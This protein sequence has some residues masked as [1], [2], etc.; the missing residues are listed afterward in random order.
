MQLTDDESLVEAWKDG[1]SHA[2]ATLF[3]RYYVP[4]CAHA[5]N[6]LRDNHASKDIVQQVFTGILLSKLQN[7]IIG[8][9]LKGYLFTAV[10][11]RCIRE[12]DNRKRHLV[13]HERAK[14]LTT[15]VEFPLAMEDDEQTLAQRKA[16]ALII[17]GLPKQ[18]R[19]AVR[20]YYIEG[21]KKIEVAQRMGIGLDSVK[22]HLRL[23]MVTIRGKIQNI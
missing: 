3:K 18:R 4:L 20:L 12:L 21:L 17:E 19:R 10:Y 9:T 22:T 6:L 13:H 2:F 11:N 1:D 16:L 5:Y 14:S 15:S 23:A 8:T 7:S